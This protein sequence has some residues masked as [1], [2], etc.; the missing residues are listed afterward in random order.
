M[1]SSLPP[2]WAALCWCFL[3]RAELSAPRPR[4]GSVPLPMQVQAAVHGEQPHPGG[5]YARLHEPPGHDFQ[6]VWA[7]AQGEWARQVS[8]CQE[9]M[10]N[11]L[12]R[13][14][15]RPACWRGSWAAR[16]CGGGQP[17]AGFTGWGCFRVGLTLGPLLP[18]EVVCLD[19]CLLLLH[20]LR[21]LQELRGHQA[22]DEQLHVS[23]G[24][25]GYMCIMWMVK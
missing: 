12:L 21:Q 5:P 7:D 23:L 15:G 17:D 8:G 3:L 22:D 16:L 13:F 1:N 2:L 4:Q 14:L 25:G 9:H 11:M 6:H 19:R 10:E 18:A 20:Q 24:P